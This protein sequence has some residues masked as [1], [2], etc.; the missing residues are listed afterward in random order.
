LTISDPNAVNSPQLVSV[1]LHVEGPGIGLSQSRHDF[2]A[3][4][5]GE[6][7]DD[8][9]LT[10]SNSGG[11][12]LNWQIESDSSCQWLQVAPISGSITDQTDEVV[13]TVDTT[14]L[15]AGDYNCGF[16][17][18]AAEATNSPQTAWV[19]LHIGEELFVPSQYPTIQSAIDNS[20]EFDTIMVA[21]GRYY[22]HIEVGGRNIVIT[23]TDPDDPGVVGDTVIDAEHIAPV[24]TFSGNEPADCR[25]E[26]LTLTGG[27][28]SGWGAG[29]VGKGTAASISN[30]IIEQNHSE[31]NGAGIHGCRG[32]IS[33]CLIRNNTTIT[34]G[35]G[36]AACHGRI[37]DCV[38]TGNT[39]LGWETAAAA[40]HNCDGQIVNC[41]V[42]DNTA[43]GG[44]GLRDCDGEITN[45][46]IWGDEGA[47]LDMSV[48]P[49][50]SCYPY[51]AGNGNIGADPA[52]FFP[53]DYRLTRESPCVD[54]GRNDPANGLPATDFDGNLR[55][56]DGDGNG[57][58]VVDMGAYEYDSQAVYILVSTQTLEFNAMEGEPFWGR[59]TFL[60][61]NGGAGLLDWQITENS[62][63]LSVVPGTGSTGGQPEEVGVIVDTPGLSKGR[64]TCRLTISDPSAVN[65]PRDVKITLYVRVEGEL[66]VPAIHP[67]IQSAIDVA[68]SGDIIVVDDGVYTGDGN[69]D[70]D[71]KGKA[72]TLRSENGPENCKRRRRAQL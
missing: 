50:Y 52:F 67:T 62:D 18:S 28:N 33:N 24:V 27:Y 64:Y 65:G 9:I 23:S 34:S 46:I 12:T 54:A 55:L 10:I 48:E 14:G 5:E 57:E 1:G 32:L 36:L 38:I 8:Q 43:P 51:G 35:G 47:G 4:K 39:A 3:A 7:P 20:R 44:V 45:C 21:P 66:S 70:I 17:V 63:W 6:Y 11:G 68:V 16:T 69:R 40:I 58:A 37:V 13:L 29:I 22:E 42:A 53:D 26:G 71:F 49:S 56:L 31:Y 30:C 25:L 59:R 41:T 2:F 72:I 19:H 61:A 15:V 60:I